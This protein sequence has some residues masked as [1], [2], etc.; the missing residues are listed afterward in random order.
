MGGIYITL[1]CTDTLGGP[2][3]SGFIVIKVVNINRNPL[4]ADKNIQK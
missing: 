4:S 1:M 2:L 3:D